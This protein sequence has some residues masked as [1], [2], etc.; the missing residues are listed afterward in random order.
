[1]AKARKQIAIFHRRLDILKALKIFIKR[2][3]CP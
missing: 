3:E 2:M 1:M